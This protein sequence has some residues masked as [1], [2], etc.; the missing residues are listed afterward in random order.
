MTEQC[1]PGTD[2]WFNIHARF[3]Q[4]F[5]HHSLKHCVWKKTTA[6]AAESIYSVSLKDFIHQ[7]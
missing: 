4:L 3:Y 6:I 2:V 7:F 1:F 5:A